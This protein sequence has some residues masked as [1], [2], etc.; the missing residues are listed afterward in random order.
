MGKRKKEES[1]PKPGDL[2]TSR[3]GRLVTDL[4]RDLSRKGKHR[5]KRI[6][7]GS[8][9][10]DAVGIA[11]YGTHCSNF[12]QMGRDIK[13]YDF[14]FISPRRMPIDHMRNFC[15]EVA[16][17]GGF[18]Y[19]YFFDDDTVNDINVIGRL[20]PRMK[21]FNAISASYYIRGVP[22]LPMVFKWRNRKKFQMTLYGL[23]A[24]KNIDKDGVL[25]KDVAGVGCGCTLFRT[26]DFTKVPYP[27]FK[28]AYGHTEDA[29]FFTQA[30][31]NIED[32]KVGMDFT[33]ACGH[34]MDPLFVDQ[35]NVHVMRRLY[36]QLKKT[37]GAFQ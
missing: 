14:V 3:D 28:T 15:V 8:L 26:K 9:T 37:G 4:N 16:I 25:R 20:I 22:F 19:L 1:G 10:L 32:Y 33:I 23:N 24:E 29:W 17:K 34:L 35:N 6:L 13:D 5:Q 7:V 21:E 30:H 11:P 12:Y 36:K 27:W 2:I 18:E 31:R